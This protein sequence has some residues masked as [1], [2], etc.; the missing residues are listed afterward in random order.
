MLKPLLDPLLSLVFPPVCEICDR[1]SSDPSLCRECRA[2]IVLIKTPQRTVEG[3]FYD[4]LFVASVYDGVMK[5]LLQRYKFAGRRSL[6][7][8]FCHMLLECIEHY[9]VDEN[10]DGVLAVPLDSARL[11]ERGFN[12]SSL[13]AKMLAK[14]KNLPHLS[15]CLYRSASQVPQSKLGKNMRRTNVEN[16]FKVMSPDVVKNRS[17]LLIDDIVTT[18]HTASECARALKAAG[19]QRV[20]VL[21]LARGV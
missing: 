17:L 1:P 2:K 12:Q 20:T 6:K 13:L 8:F 3:F 15:S 19:A 10:Y 7:E 18:G 16:K 4:R 11:H 21:A 14:K 5:E 9:L